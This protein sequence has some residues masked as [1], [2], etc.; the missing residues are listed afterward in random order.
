MKFECSNGKPSDAPAKKGHGR[1]KNTTDTNCSC[2]FLKI[3][4]H[5]SRWGAFFWKR[6]PTAGATGGSD[7]IRLDRAEV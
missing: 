7:N 6:T 4:L 3:A 5:V 1:G 2:T